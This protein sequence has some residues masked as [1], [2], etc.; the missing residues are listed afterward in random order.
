MDHDLNIYDALYG[1]FENPVYRKIRLETYGRDIGQ[2]GWLLADEFDRFL[3]LL[4]L[5]GKSSAIEVASGSGGPA[6][7]LAKSSGCALTGIDINPQ[8]ITRAN[9]AARQP[10]LTTRV[11]FLQGDATE[12]LPFDNDSADCILCFDAINHFPDR[13]AVLKDWYR[14]LKLGGRAIFTDPIVITGFLTNREIQTRSSIGYFLYAPHGTNERLLRESGFE[15]LLA[16]NSTENIAQIAK[17]WKESRDRNRDELLQIEG[18]KI[19]EGTQ[20]FLEMARLLAAE[21]R[22]SRYTYLA[23]KRA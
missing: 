4:G 23:Q 5:T 7:A 12:R 15:I 8:A 22:L 17:R 9:A 1:S 21:K 3:R 10:G 18:A 11:R 20:E 13:I 2:T 6:I 14:I 16:E 19:Y